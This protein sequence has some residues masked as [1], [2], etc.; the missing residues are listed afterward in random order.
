MKLLSFFGYL[1]DLLYRVTNRL[2]MYINYHRFSRI[3][4]H[5]KFFP[6]NSHF[7]YK[8]I[9]MGDDISINPGCNFLTYKSKLY[10]GN[11]VLFGPNVTIRGGNH[12]YDVVGKFIWDIGE[13]EKRPEDDQDVV[14]EDD[15]WV[16]CNVTI[17]KGVHVGRGAIIGAGAV[18]TKSVAP[19]SIYGGVP[20]KKIRN[21]FA[22]VE[23][24]IEHD[25][26]LFLQ[27]AL[28][29]CALREEFNK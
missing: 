22:T 7:V 23:E 11:K 28:Q 26:K 24:T 15:V 14:I 19:Y 10:I 8:N 4:K 20:A 29:D 27:N 21:R 25:H 9:E 6:L 18:V 16:G 17:L 5:V 2:L 13:D 1:L 3:G 12:P